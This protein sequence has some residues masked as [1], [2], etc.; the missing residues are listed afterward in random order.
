MMD[1]AEMLVEAVVQELRI[2]A[3]MA[4]PDEITMDVRCF[5][6][7]HPAGLV[8]VD[9]GPGSV[10]AIEAALGRIGAG[11]GEV[12]DVVLTHWHPDHV[13][14]LA[15]VVARSPQAVVWA[16]AADC[17]QISSPVPLRP[18]AEGGTVRDLRVLATPGHTPGHICLVLEDGTLIVGDAAAS[19]AGAL[20]RPPEAFTAD[21]GQAEESLRKLSRLEPARVLFS[22]GPE[23]PDPAGALRRLLESTPEGS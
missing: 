15:E 19:S 2:P 7:S 9:T 1:N 3:G 20:M 14:G 21:T 5:L 17:Q 8:L 13:G 16:G 10:E 12:T 11:W 4:G 18:L 6:V 23:V 22:H